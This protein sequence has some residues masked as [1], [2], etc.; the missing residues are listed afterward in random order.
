MRLLQGVFVSIKK[1]NNKSSNG[2]ILVS[3]FVKNFSVLLLH[4]NFARTS[5][6]KTLFVSPQILLMEFLRLQFYY[7]DNKHFIQAEHS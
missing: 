5:C 7:N 4:E 2:L 1:N 6:F 3:Q